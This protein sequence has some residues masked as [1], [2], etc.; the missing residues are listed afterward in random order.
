MNQYELKLGKTIPLFFIKMTDDQKSK[1][2]LQVG[3]SSLLIPTL[4]VKEIDHALN[5]WIRLSKRQSVPVEYQ[6]VAKFKK[7]P[8]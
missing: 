1:I 5:Y 8:A 4:S 7:V 2:K 6:R 3:T